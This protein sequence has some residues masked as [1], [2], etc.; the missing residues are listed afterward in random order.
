MPF[1]GDRIAEVLADL[2]RG[3]RYFPNYRVRSQQIELARHFVR[4]LKNGGRL[5]LEG[6]T[7]VG[8]SLAYLAAAIPF[9][10]ERAADGER[11]PIVISTRTKL[12]QDQLLNKDIPARVLARWSVGRVR[13]PGRL[14]HES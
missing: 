3:R 2:E 13:Q 7:G 10:M 4:T 6:G 8:K 14:H 11:E 5:L 9:A 12:L 1:D